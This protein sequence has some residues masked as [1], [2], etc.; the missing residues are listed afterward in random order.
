MEEGLIPHIRSMEDPQEIEEERRLTYVGM[1]RAKE[2]L[3]MTRSFNRFFRGSSGPTLPS[4]FL[5]EIPSGITDRIPKP[6]TNRISKSAILTNAETTKQAINNVTNLKTGDKINHSK[7]GEGIIVSSIS[8]AAGDE[9]IT[10]AFQGDI[11]IKK[12]LLGFAP[13]E[14]ID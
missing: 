10:V 13:I 8:S 2:R 11:G 3:Y 12:L 1:T 7:F 5:S 9:E 14:K 4:R 6:E